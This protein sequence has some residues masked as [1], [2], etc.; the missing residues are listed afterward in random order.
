MTKGSYVRIIPIPQRANFIAEFVGDK[1][2]LRPKRPLMFG[3]WLEGTLRDD[4]VQGGKIWLKGS[5][6]RDGKVIAKSWRSL[7]IVA[8]VGEHVLCERGKYRLLRVPPYQRPPH[9]EERGQ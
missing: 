6:L 2:R 3:H 8:I 4:L 9:H 1:P 7:R 5:H